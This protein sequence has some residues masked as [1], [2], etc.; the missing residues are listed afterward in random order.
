ME[1]VQ[2]KRKVTLR[3]KEKPAEFTF[4]GLL[5]VKLLWQSSTDLDLCI[6]FKKKDGDVGGVFSSAFR[7]RKSDLGS[8]TEF[9]YM[10]HKGDEAEPEA[11]GESVEQINIANLNE[12][13]TAYICVLNYGKAIEG[14]EVNFAHDSG[15]IEIMSDNGDYFEVVIDAEQQGHVYHVCSI[16]NHEGENSV[17]NEGVVMDLG[18]AF[19]K[20]PGFSLICE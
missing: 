17:M 3:R 12:I 8:L 19:D 11:G 14:K 7:Q 10:L 13:D 18:T 1:G 6:F 16:K 5:K 20:I 15:R 9:P 2:L 4:T